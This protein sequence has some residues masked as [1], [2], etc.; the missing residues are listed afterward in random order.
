MPFI[1][2]QMAD[3]GGMILEEQVYRVAEAIIYFLQGLGHSKFLMMLTHLK[4][5]M[6]S[7]IYLPS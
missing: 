2:S 6:I 7:I 3:A 1:P 4:S 5:L